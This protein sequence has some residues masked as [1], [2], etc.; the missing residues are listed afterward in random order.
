ML[1]IRRAESAE[2]FLGGAISAAS[3]LPPARGSGERCKLSQ[4]L[5]VGPG[6]APETCDIYLFLDLR[7]CRKWHNRDTHWFVKYVFWHCTG[8]HKWATGRH[9]GRLVTMLKEAM[10]IS[11]KALLSLPF[12]NTVL[13]F[14]YFVTS[15]NICY[16]VPCVKIQNTYLTNTL[17]CVFRLYLRELTGSVQP[18]KIGERCCH[19]MHFESRI[20]M[21]KF[22]LW[23]GLHTRPCWGSL[24]HS[25]DPLAGFW[26]GKGVQKGVE[27]GKGQS[28]ERPDSQAKSGCSF[29]MYYMLLSSWLT[30]NVWKVGNLHGN[31][32]LISD[33][34]C[35]SECYMC[36]EIDEGKIAYLLKCSWILPM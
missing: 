12:F 13:F 36:C 9:S 11:S 31:C 5:A 3:P 22:V 35:T 20:N 23:P 34:L 2:G 10:S 16:F 24:Q 32:I 21:S 15:F 6:R 27:G 17:C 8:R 19:E 1:E 29:W 4:W 33:V 25:P 30:Y 14:Q 28:R 18:P 7:Q 26:G